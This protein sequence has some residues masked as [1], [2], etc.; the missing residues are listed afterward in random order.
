[1][2]TIF[3]VFSTVINWWFHRHLFTCSI[4]IDEEANANDNDNEWDSPTDV[5]FFRTHFSEATMQM[6]EF[7][8]TRWSRSPK[9]PIRRLIAFFCA[10][11]ATSHA[12]FRSLSFVLRSCLFVIPVHC[13]FLSISRFFLLFCYLL[14]F[15][16]C[17]MIIFWAGVAFRI[18]ICHWFR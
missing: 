11:A 1:M 16:T 8:V 12:F 6:Q 15:M 4:I 10:L 3:V 7:T 14:I 13:C 9:S 2:M 18:P 5:R 17:L